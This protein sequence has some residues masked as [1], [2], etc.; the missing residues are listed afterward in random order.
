M[1]EAE[2]QGVLGRK[3]QAARRAHEARAMSPG[4]ALRR[5][6]A[7]TAD[8]LWGLALMAQDDHL[9]DCDQ[10]GVV[11]AIDGDHLLMLLDGPDGLP[12]VVSVDRAAMTAMIEVQTLRQVTQLPLDDRPMTQTDA[13]MLAPFVDGVL[14][15]MADYLEGDPMQ[16]ATAGFRFGALIEDARAA[17]LLLDAPGYYLFRV[18]V[19]LALG[20]RRGTIQVV[21][22]KRPVCA[23]QSAEG[24]GDESAGPYSDTLMQVPA[25]LEAVLARVPVSLDTVQT[26]APGDLIELP[27]DALDGLVLHSRFGDPVA[28]GRLGQLNGMR[29]VRLT[30]PLAEGATEAVDP[31]GLVDEPGETPKLAPPDQS[32]KP[33]EDVQID[34]TASANVPV[35]APQTDG[36]DVADFDLGEFAFDV[37]PLE[38]T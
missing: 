23:G 36:F 38:E 32:A 8:V 9:V 16:S 10:D 30:W 31:A 5:A 7:R 20:R 14:A 37:A 4:K 29:A 18:D 33:V 3:A 25:R 35:P 26:L 2:R 13:A 17:S 34:P 24:D 15:R 12:G 6:M 11:H 1:A 21:L 27:A 22:P 28:G 19:D